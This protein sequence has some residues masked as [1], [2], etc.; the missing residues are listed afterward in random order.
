MPDNTLQGIELFMRGMGAI[1]DARR[2]N[3]EDEQWDEFFKIYETMYG[4]GDDESTQPRPSPTNPYLKGGAPLPGEFPIS[5]SPSTVDPNVKQLMMQSM[6][7][8]RNNKDLGQRQLDRNL[9]GIGGS[10]VPP[11]SPPSPDMGAGKVTL[12]PDLIRMLLM[13]YT[14]P[15]GMGM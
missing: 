15:Q 6:I 2:A 5:Q 3:K 1:G 7:D 12:P 10:P 11:T 13:G 8:N 4:E 9:A 14:R